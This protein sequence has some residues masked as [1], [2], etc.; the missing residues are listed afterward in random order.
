MGEFN[1]FTNMIIG[2]PPVRVDDK[3]YLGKSKGSGLFLSSY[4]RLCVA[5]S[6]TISFDTIKPLEGL[7]GVVRSFK[8]IFRGV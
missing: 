8:G 3:I 1:R 7:R 2:G 4:H 6:L 5:R